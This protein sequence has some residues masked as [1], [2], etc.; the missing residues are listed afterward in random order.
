MKVMK[1]CQNE[2]MRWKPYHWVY[3]TA[4]LKGKY[5]GAQDQ[6]NGIWKIFNR[7]VFLEDFNENK[8]QTSIN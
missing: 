5:I 1:A 4:S 6:G 2:S 7:D 3:L 8:R